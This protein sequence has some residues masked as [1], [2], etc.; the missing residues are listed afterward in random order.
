MHDAAKDMQITATM[1]REFR[2]RQTVFMTFAR[3]TTWGSIVVRREG[4]LTYD[5]RMRSRTA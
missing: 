3:R 2:L 5:M 4:R 1:I